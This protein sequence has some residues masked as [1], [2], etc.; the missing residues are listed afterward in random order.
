MKRTKEIQEGKP[1][2]FLSV[3]L[4]LVVIMF[5]VYYI[6][7]LF[8]L[9][10]I[11]YF[12]AAF[13]FVS[14]KASLF[15]TQ[16]SVGKFIAKNGIMMVKYSLF[17]LGTYVILWNV[18]TFFSRAKYK[19]WIRPFVLLSFIVCFIAV[20]IIVYAFPVVSHFTLFALVNDFLRLTILSTG[21]VWAEI[22][23]R[24][25][26]DAYISILAFLEKYQH[27]MSQLGTFYFI[28]MV[29]F[30]L[31]SRVREHQILGMDRKSA[32]VDEHSEL[33]NLFESVHSTAMASKSFV[34]TR[35][36]L[37]R[38]ESD[39]I[40]AFAY[41]RNRVCITKGMEMLV[42]QGHYDIAK[43]IIAHEIGH[44]ANR[45]TTALQIASVCNSFLLYLVLIPL[46]ISGRILEMISLGIP[47][48][49]PIVSLFGNQIQSWC[50][51]AVRWLFGFTMRIARVAGGRKDE[52]RADAFAAECGY[53]EGLVRFF[54]LY[55]PESGGGFDEH[56]KMRKRIEN[57]RRYMVSSGNGTSVEN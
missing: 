51:N 7:T 26:Q 52:N 15:L 25:S 29:V 43:G 13:D 28:W 31:V 53:G 50:E 42:S 47:L 17:L 22:I 19:Y 8:S 14:M 55:D 44:L 9:A 24:F 30:Y 3:L 1:H 4:L 20:I 39:Q 32:R 2:R 37:F 6:G 5:L 33:F 18:V 40:N 11:E 41:G 56:P 46:N 16:T 45:D 34:P 10:Y 48:A 12:Q 54:S 35:I 36:K 57:I 49:G 27:V 21:I 23:G 38:S